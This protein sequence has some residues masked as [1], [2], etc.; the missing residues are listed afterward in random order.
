MN[1]GRRQGPHLSPGPPSHRRWAL[2]NMCGASKV[3]K[4]P[5]SLATLPASAA[6]RYVFGARLSAPVH[7][8]LV[9]TDLPSA[10]GRH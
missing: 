5:R 10:S 2:W 9:L 4:L 7:V 8:S 1:T 6:R 3:E